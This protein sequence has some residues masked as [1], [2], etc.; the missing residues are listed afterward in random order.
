MSEGLETWNALRRRARLRLLRM[1]FESGV[2]HIGGNLSCLDLLLI[3]HHAI[4][5]PGDQFVLS[6][7]HSA[8]AY[9][10]T[11]W[12]LGRL[13][14]ED[15]RQF[16]KEGTALS[17]HPPTAGIEDILFA[18]GS[19]GHGLSL[20]I[21][22]ALAKRLKGEPGRV[23]CLMSD[24]EWNEGSCWEALIFARHQRLD[25]LTFLVD[26]NGLQGFGPTREVANLDPLA[27]KFRAFEVPALEID[28]HD[29]EAIRRALGHD[30]SGLNAIVAR[31][32]KG[33]GVSF[34]EDRTEWH[35]LPLS[36]SQYEQA[37]QETE[38]A[39]ATF[40]ASPSSRPPAI[41]GSSS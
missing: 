26:L 25:N 15:L 21:G 17:G 19:L 29:F 23:Y 30:P 9:Y 28:G 24:G 18:T 16:H 2:G 10:V 39:C 32:H 22:L 11:L 41:P 20:S 3:L 6:K 14:D 35:Y 34:M 8:G 27:E 5:R 13:Q 31:T 33:S 1:H 7:G 40:S 38:R 37:V 12:T 36:K 4:L